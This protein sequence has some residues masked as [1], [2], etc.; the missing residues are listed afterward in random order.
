MTVRYTAEVLCVGELMWHNVLG[1]LEEL[2][3]NEDPAIR[4]PI[5]HIILNNAVSYA[6]VINTPVV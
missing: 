4:V 6:R 2:G 3:D 5:A 1:F